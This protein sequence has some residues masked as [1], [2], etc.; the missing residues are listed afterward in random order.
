MGCKLNSN[1]IHHVLLP[2]S[3]IYLALPMLIFVI[4]WLKWYFAIPTASLILSPLR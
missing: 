3:L 4:G 1:P 2:T